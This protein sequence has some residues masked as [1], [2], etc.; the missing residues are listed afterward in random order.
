MSSLSNWVIHALE[1]YGLLVVFLTMVAEST[2]IPIPSEVVVPYGGVLAAQGHVQL[3]AVI[4]VACVANMVGCSIAYVV[5]RYGGRALFVHYGRYVGVSRRHLEQADAW[6]D[7]R[8]EVTVFFTRL[9][10]GV[11]TFISLPA[12][13]M[14]MNP[15]KFLLYSLLGSIPWNVGLAFLGY[16]FGANWD[17]L[18][19]QFSR[20]N[21]IFYVVLALAVIGLI[22]WG[23][24]HWRRRSRMRIS[25]ASALDKETPDAG[26]AQE[27]APKESEIG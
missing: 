21:D 8:G 23:V 27:L 11:R 9:M 7:R 15:G 2:C 1:N 24:W 14:K 13:I 19:G 12:G 16:E 26:D 22:G 17:H 20:Y 10:P 4:V 6:F 18:Q 3:W 5:G 25:A